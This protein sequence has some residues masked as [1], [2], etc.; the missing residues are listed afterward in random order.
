MP[1]NSPAIVAGLS[2]SELKSIMR[3]DPPAGEP[4]PRFQA[5][6]L[7][8]PIH[9]RPRT[10]PRAAVDFTH[11]F[12]LGFLAVFLLVVEIVTG[13]FLMF[14]Y[15]PT[16]ESAYPSIL[17][18]ISRVPFGEIVRDVHR[19]AAEAMV[20]VVVLH[21]IRVFLTAAYKDQRRV[22]W[23]LGVGQLLIVLG[24]AFTGY[25]L[26]WDQLAYWAVTIGTT[27]TDSVPYI[28][29]W[30]NL[31]LRGAPDLGPTD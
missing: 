11:T 9:L 6:R 17:R 5:H 8:F 15:V 26:P 14:Y 4:N 28:G 16:P 20:V 25:L 10:Y 27:M 21:M 2:A 29:S 1:K 13:L 7:S 18:L 30:L 22:T 3:G 19:L 12:R 31:M 24:L 23:V